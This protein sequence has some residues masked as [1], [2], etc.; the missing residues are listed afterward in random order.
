MGATGKVALRQIPWKEMVLWTAASYLC[1]GLALI[2]AGAH[3]RLPSTRTDLY[4]LATALIPAIGLVVYLV[5]LNRGAASRVV[6][7]SA[8][9]PLVTVALAYAFLGEQITGW[10]VLGALLVVGGVVL[11]VI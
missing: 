6:P 1:L 8:A 5:A 10:H 11:L 4:G 9:Y 3:F 2:I 7:V